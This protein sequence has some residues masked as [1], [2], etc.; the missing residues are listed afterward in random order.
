MNQRNQNLKLLS[1]ASA[2][3]QYVTAPGG[4][5]VWS[6]QGTFGS[7]TLTL[8]AKGPDGSTA[9]D[10]AVMTAAGAVAV[11]VGEGT[12]MRVGVTGGSPSALYSSLKGVI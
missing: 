5:Y 8:Q 9:M 10:V 1:N 12:D 3:G 6:C 2:T 11:E 7:A 4:R